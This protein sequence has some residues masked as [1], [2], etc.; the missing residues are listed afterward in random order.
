VTRTRAPLYFALVLAALGAG[1]LGYMLLPPETAQTTVHPSTEFARS[2]HGV[3]VLVLW[4]TFVMFVLVEGLLVV[5]MVRFRERDDA[6]PEQTHGNLPLEI[7]W[8]LLTTVLVLVMFVPSCQQI[9]FAQGKPPA[10]DPLRIVVDGRQWWWE[11]YYPEYDFL[12]ANELVLPTG[13]TALLEIGSSDVIHS[14]WIPRLGGKRDAV[15]GRTQTL[16]FTPETPGVYQGQCAE[17]CGTSHTHMSLHAIVVEPQ[18]FAAWVERQR[19]PTLPA[20]QPAAQQGQIAFLTSGCVACHSPF[21]NDRAVRGMLGPNLR[22]L[23]TR[24]RIAAG[25]LENTPENLFHWIK[26]PQRVK[27]GALMNVPAPQCTD[28]AAPEP[29]CT[30]AGTGN[31][32]SDETVEQIV[33]YLRSLG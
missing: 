31:C 29:C 20:T 23:G 22:K 25:L 5:A 16:W 7:G 18:E 28:A 30:G 13:R 33:A 1:W 8:T 4:F 10:D 6:L 24:R 12:T 11:F 2:S 32:L 17:Y 15:P 14:F 3:Y 21:Q 27:P 26:N 9:Q 19:A